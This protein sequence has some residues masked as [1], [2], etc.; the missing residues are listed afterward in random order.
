MQKIISQHEG[1]SA[2]RQFLQASLI[3]D[4]SDQDLKVILTIGS[5]RKAL[6]KQWQDTEFLEGDSVITLV[7]EILEVRGK[8]TPISIVFQR[9]EQ[10][11]F[12]QIL[13]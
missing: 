7:H 10:L 8:P 9:S 11:Y 1:Y 2:L 6:R 5:E 3:Q 13:C 12:E 4:T